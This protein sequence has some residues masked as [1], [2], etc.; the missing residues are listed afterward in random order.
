MSAKRKDIDDSD[1]Q[2]MY[3]VDGMTQEEIANYY[4]VSQGCIR[5]RLHPDKKKEH[6]GKY[7]EKNARHL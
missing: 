1:V 6:N 5:D 2:Y 7:K 3:K 4:G